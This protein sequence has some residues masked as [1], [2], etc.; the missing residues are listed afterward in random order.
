MAGFEA[1]QS[2][3]GESTA[4]RRP[5][6]LVPEGIALAPHVTAMMDVS[7]GLLLDALRMARA[8]GVTLAIDSACVPIAVPE[9][10][11]Q[12][13]MRWGDDYQLLF[14]MPEGQLP[15]VAATAIGQVQRQGEAPLLLDE[16]PL[17]EAD[18]LGFEH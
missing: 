1:L 4:N 11:R 13:A 18:G 2:G 8:S 12:D 15:P 9:A 7:D 17:S 14:S 6:A 16:K 3:S 5:K 10:R